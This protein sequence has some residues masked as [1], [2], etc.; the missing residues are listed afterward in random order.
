M[1]AFV[2]YLG[3]RNGTKALSTQE[4]GLQQHG[5]KRFTC[6]GLSHWLGILIGLPLPHI[7]MGYI[8]FWCAPC[9]VSFPPQ[10]HP[11][12][13]AREGERAVSS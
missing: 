4:M 12:R 5:S 7:E 2:K 1:T 10:Y 6:G 8:I 3:K 9:S 11:Q 13:E